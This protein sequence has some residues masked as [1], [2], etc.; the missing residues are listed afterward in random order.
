[1]KLTPF[2]NSLSYTEAKS[3]TMKQVED[4]YA[5]PQNATFQYKYKNDLLQKISSYDH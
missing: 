5:T 1:M 2:Q 4:S 3:E